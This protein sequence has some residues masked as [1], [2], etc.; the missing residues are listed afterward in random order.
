M[1]PIKLI[2]PISSSKECCEISDKVETGEAWSHKEAQ[3]SRQGCPE[4]GGVSEREQHTP[5]QLK[6]LFTSSFNLKLSFEL[7]KGP[8]VSVPLSQL[9]LQ[10]R[11]N[12][13]GY[14]KFS[15]S[16]TLFLKIFPSQGP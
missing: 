4:G 13:S 2:I 15:K 1:P 11:G 16:K 12:I 14:R 10:K 3:R 8:Q 5:E 7:N 6:C 9:P